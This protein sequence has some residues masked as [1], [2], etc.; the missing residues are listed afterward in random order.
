MATAAA[1]DAASP[2]VERTRGLE[3]VACFPRTAPANPYLDLLYG[4]LDAHGLE[5]AED[6]E[7]TFGWLRS[8]RRRVRTI[9]VHWPE[10]LYRV[11]RQLPP[12][13]AGAARALKLA[14]F[15]G[16]LAAARLLGYRIVWTV[17]QPLPHER[18]AG[19]LP[20]ARLLARL[21]HAL[22]AHDETTSRRV[23]DVLGANPR[24]LRIV[25]HGAYSGVY[26][27]TVGRAATRRALGIAD[28]EFVFLSFGE[29]RGYKALDCLLDAWRLASAP[30]A[31]LVIA[32]NPKDP[33]L[34]ELLRERAAED[35]SIVPLLQHV[36][37]EDVADLYAAADAAVSARSDGG[38]SGSLVLALSLGVP[39]VAADTETARE[40]LGGNDA[41]WL[42]T[43]GDTAAA[44][45]ALERAVADPEN[46]RRRRAARA[47]AARLA[48][49][50]IA[51]QTAECL[52]GEQASGPFSIV[53]LSSEDWDAP[54]PTNRQQIM[55][56]AAA[57]G[58][59]VL[60]V[61]TNGWLGRHLWR[62]V[63]QRRREAWRRL[64]RTEHVAERVERRKALNL[65]PWGQKFS[66][67]RAV[68]ARCTEWLVR[69]A[70][71]RLPGP[72][73]VWVYDPA[74]VPGRGTTLPCVYDCVDDYAEQV[75]PD[76]RR[77]ALVAAADATAAERAALVFATARPL[78]VRHAERNPK[79]HLV[80]NV[81]D[82][83]HFATAA[84]P[85]TATP[86]LRRLQRP[87]FGF[88]GS[89][90]ADKVDFDLLDHIAAACPDAT[91]L[92]V[93]PVAA[94]ADARV[95]SLQA[96]PNVV[97]A[98]PCTYEKLPSYVAAFDVALIPYAA[99]PYT[100]SC[101]PLKVYEYLAAGKPVVA[102]G[103][104][105][106][107]GMEPDVA[108]AG[109]AADVAAELNRALAQR[110]EADVARR[111]SVARAHTWDTRT[112]RL[113][114]LVERELGSARPA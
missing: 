5:R 6:A 30:T 64:A 15:A 16:R 114:E 48:W 83:G 78:Y 23:V 108:L 63:V 42:F 11:S 107:Q 41:A 60:F 62:A 105:E 56:R 12:G 82:Y 76:A 90:T 66:V 21:A 50:P 112:G 7:F 28:D 57:R 87:I 71:R 37:D 95:F 59:Q 67:A 25:P 81:A 69:R 27:E 100:R 96:R 110:S 26:A 29:L 86:A 68:N 99:T 53:C 35:P 88:A 40:V 17:H 44:A 77:R 72:C 65:I 36:P 58:H 45:A 1:F 84:D 73:V 104:P 109:G 31:R 19:D 80:P 49:P 43:S 75:G 51:E 111:Q 98:G 55:R 101:F 14:L 24:R 9:H 10:G 8:A 34:A 54:L 3:L 13:A 47:A 92:L 70:A 85:S 33:K 91:L 79:T 102:T 103:L 89:I 38:T 39:V 22:I 2:P 94:N 106:L 93:G 97:W 113:L 32:G 52:L 74:A 61:E 18:T 46:A 4:A 20:A